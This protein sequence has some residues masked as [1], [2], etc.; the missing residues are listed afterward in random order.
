MTEAGVDWFADSG[1]T[2]HM[3][4]N[5]KLFTNLE[6]QTSTAWNIKGVMTIIATVVTWRITDTLV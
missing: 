2:R 6:E 4:G 5:R 1:A 3:S